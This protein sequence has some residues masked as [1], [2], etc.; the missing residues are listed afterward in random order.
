MSSSSTGARHQPIMVYRGDTRAPGEIFKDG[1]KSR[2]GDEELLKHV[3]G[4][5]N[6]LK[7]GYISTSQSL[8]LPAAFLTRTDESYVDPKNREVKYDR[9]VGWVYHINTTGLNMS[10]VPD[11]LPTQKEKNQYGYQQEWATKGTIPGKNIKLAQHVDGYIKR[12]SD[13]CNMK[14]GVDPIFPPE[15]PTPY[16]EQKLNPNYGFK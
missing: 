12:Y 14:Q 1:F 4:A 6:L 11:L 2:G 15:K 7:S 10:Y 5:E 16:K 13:L 3:K 8:R 9:R